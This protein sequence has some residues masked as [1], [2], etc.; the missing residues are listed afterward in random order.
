MFLLVS[1]LC[2]NSKFLEGRVYILCTV[3]T[4]R[5]CVSNGGSRYGIGSG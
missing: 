2:L 1:F 5:D 4:V 3:A